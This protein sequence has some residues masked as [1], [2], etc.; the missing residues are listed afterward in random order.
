M[1]IVILAVVYFLLPTTVAF[2]DKIEGD[3]TLLETDWVGPVIAILVI[4]V[5]TLIAKRIKGSR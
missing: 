4:F 1:K 2:A 5:A 3:A